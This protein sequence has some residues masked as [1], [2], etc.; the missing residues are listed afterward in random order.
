MANL[1]NAIANQ[2]RESTLT[3]A[4]RE[5]RARVLKFLAIARIVTAAWAALCCFFFAIYPTVL[6]GGAV[7]V[8]C[9]LTY[10][11]WQVTGN[12]REIATNAL[13]EAAINSADGVHVI[14]Q[15]TRGAPLIRALVEIIIPP[16][17]FRRGPVNPLDRRIFSS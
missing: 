9:Y 1:I 13:A 4:E 2:V 17:T 14:E 12:V 5:D 11:A 7:L 16:S 6:S 15:L 8:A 3:P 10:E